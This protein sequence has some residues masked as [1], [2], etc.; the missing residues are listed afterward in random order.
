MEITEVLKKLNGVRRL[1]TGGYT[2]KCP[3][4]D[5]KHNSLVIG[6]GK[7]SKILLNCKAGCSFEDIVKSMGLTGGDMRPTSTTQTKTYSEVKCV[8]TA[9][10]LAKKK[11]IPLKFLQGL[12]VY[13]EEDG[14][15]IPYLDGN[16]KNA[17]RNRI[18]KG[19]SSSGSRWDTTGR[20]R[21]LPIG[22]YGQWLEMNKCATELIIC[23]GESNCWTLWL[24]GYPALGIPG[25]S[26]F[27][28]LNY[29]QV[30]HAKTIY[31]LKDPDQGGDTMESGLKKHLKVLG[32][33]RNLHVVTLPVKDASDFY[34]QSPDTFCDRFGKILEEVRKEASI[35]EDVKVKPFPTHVLPELFQ[36]YVKNI[37][38]NLSTNI[39]YPGVS[40]LSAV[41]LLSGN[42]TITIPS[43][44]WSTKAIMYSALIGSPG[45][46][47]T[48]AMEKTLGVVFEIEEELRGENEA[49]RNEFE[50]EKEEYRE[51][52]AEWKKNA[53]KG[54]PDTE[55]P[56]PPKEICDKTLLTTDATTESL[57]PILNGNPSLL[58]M[59][60]ELSSWINSMDQYR[61]GKGADKEF[62]LSAWS[63]TFAKIDR[64]GK[65]AIF[66]RSP[67]LSI[68]GGIVP[69]KLPLLSGNANDGFFDRLVCCYPEAMQRKWDSEKID[70]E[71]R[72]KA[73]DKLRSIY[74]CCK[75]ESPRIIMSDEA[76]A[77]FGQYYDACNGKEGDFWSKM[78]AHC[79]RIA[80]CL[81]LLHD[82]KICD[83]QIIQ[84]A[85]EFSQY[86]ESHNEKA[87]G[88]SKKSPE[89]VEQ[90]A[91]IDFAK[92]KGLSRIK[93]RTLYVAR[94][95]GCGS[96]KK[97]RE[98]MQE[99]V[100]LDMAFWVID[101]KEIEI[102]DT[103][104]P[105]TT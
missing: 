7:E 81:C 75:T 85:I 88:L 72:E 17:L 94:I 40:L 14:I 30:E 105:G 25:A 71:I 18:R 48:P 9:E 74:E 12:G 80:L 50:V 23:E 63:G 37:S 19:I 100:D 44:D 53:K 64:K 2:S 83:V 42:A 99:L 60:D 77:V 49:N 13:N 22:V 54:S 32:W 82:A 51:A 38:G 66:I 67:H 97:A 92:K 84:K 27:A 86:F 69:D 56:E 70:S 102:L 4:H 61:A 87:R 91:I 73:K 76:E 8:P 39:D 55:R 93:P 41:S 101:G 3:C 52:L 59:R 26:M 33:H 58:L 36:K 62:Y 96:A 1:T 21:D 11:F 98:K 45:S 10:E 16:G 79:L 34:V 104:N 89:E 35:G 46:G 95:R 24:N 29:P 68:L 20:T 5:D 78:P 6:E 57:G 43:K 31:L 28:K 47:K 15:C 90:N 103:G 65:P